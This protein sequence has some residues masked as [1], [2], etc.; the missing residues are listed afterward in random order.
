[1]L[2]IPLQKSLSY[3]NEAM[4]T[5]TNLWDSKA[6]EKLQDLVDDINICLFCTNIKSD[7]VSNCRPM[8]PQKTDNEGNLW[9]F[10][11]NTSEKNREIEQDKN[12]QLFF[13]S[14]SQ[15]SYLVVNGTAEIIIDTQKT[16]ELWSPIVRTWFKDGKDDPKISILK[17]RPESAYYWDTSDNRMWNFLK[18]AAS[19]A[20]GTNLVDS[21]QGSININ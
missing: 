12:V 21:Q 4:N 8:S 10:S 6:I 17:V 15:N 1:L 3:K 16:E 18:M 11:D 14:P 19:A 13:S 20:T 5:I 7:N 9:F 2:A